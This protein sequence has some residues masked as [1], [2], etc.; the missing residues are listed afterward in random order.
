MPE[1]RRRKLANAV[2]IPLRA[3]HRIEEIGD[4]W[5]AG[6]KSEFYGVGTLAVP[7]GNKRE[8]EKLEWMDVGISHHHSGCMEKGEYIPADIYQDYRGEFS[9]VHLVLDQRGN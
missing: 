7:T 8:A 2:W 3:I 4:D 9:G 5:H 6:Y 1:V